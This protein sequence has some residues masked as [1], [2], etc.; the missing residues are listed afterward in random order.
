M[1]DTQHLQ[2]TGNLPA[3]AAVTPLRGGHR[4]KRSFAI[5]GDFDFLK[6]PVSLPPL[7][8][9]TPEG[10]MEQ[11]DKF[12]G[13]EECPEIVVEHTLASHDD[14]SE[15]FSNT[16]SR[17]TQPMS[18]RFFISEEPRY[19][20]PF[21]GV[22]DAI[23]NLDDALKTKPKCF[24][25]HRRSES[26]PADLAVLLSAKTVSRSSQMIE[27][28]DDDDDGADS[29]LRTDSSGSDAVGGVVK[30]TLLSPLR[31]TSPFPVTHLQD[32][33]LDGSPVR[34]NRD[35]RN[36]NFNSLKISR[37]KQRYYQYTKKIPIGSS[38]VQSQSLREK[39]SSNSLSSACLRTPHS[40]FQTPSKQVSTPLTPVSAGLNSSNNQSES[41]NRLISPFRSQHVRSGMRNTTNSS[42]KYEPK[43][44]DMPHGR[45]NSESV[46]SRDDR[47]LYKKEMSFT[48]GCD[49][50]DE[51]GSGDESSTE[52]TSKLPISRELLFGE[53][54]EAVDL[55]SLSSPVKGTFID[56]RS[57]SNEEVSSPIRHDRGNYSE[58]LSP[59]N[60]TPDSRSVSDTLLVMQKTR[61][62]KRKVRS[63][64]NV[65]FMNI[66]RYS[67]NYEQGN[68][69]K[70]A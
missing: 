49:A 50:T 56:Y 17:E 55:S 21:R 66:F 14:E 63:K 53:P 31:P 67:T 6:Q 1:T 46:S 40:S 12:S 24:K 36:D 42:F 32:L 16:K 57:S 19:S 69:S 54:G 47:T 52:G 48:E 13:P 22:P 68:S 29:D 45:V 38:S 15:T 28:E 43:V 37:Q 51:D 4:H 44:Y 59:A 5:S 27:E 26:A 35:N 30:S 62:E 65:F 61:K 20:S 64:L 58:P 11:I 60:D 70:K 3:D 41:N 2:M 39:A 8:C 25:S 23:I 9:N 18:P 7:P 10:P 34:S 33:T